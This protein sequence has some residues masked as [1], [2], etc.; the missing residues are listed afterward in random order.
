MPVELGATPST[1]TPLLR[2]AEES[3]RADAGQD[4]QVEDRTAG[5][6]Q[7][8]FGRWSMYNLGKKVGRLSIE[9]GKLL[10]Y[11]SF[12]LRTVLKNDLNFTWEP[13]KRAWTKPVE[14]F[15]LMTGA[16]TS[17]TQEI[18]RLLV[19]S[20][21]KK[22]KEQDQ[23]QVSERSEDT[24]GSSAGGSGREEVKV[25]EGEGKLHVYN[26]YQVKEEL[27]ALGFVFDSTRKSWCMQLFAALNVLD[28]ASSSQVDLEVIRRAASSSKLAPSG[29]LSVSSSRFTSAEFE[30]TQVKLS[31]GAVLTLATEL[32]E[33]SGD[34]TVAGGH[35]EMSTDGE[36]AASC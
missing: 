7:D 34:G 2:V 22:V 5:L 6:A 24:S 16:A 9:D 4:E 30:A 26:S 33:Q 3:Q 11:Q 32:Q 10:A 12:P 18:F 31:W 25:E 36:A 20:Y 29:S 28:V 17:D 21:N 13:E 27:K 1:S 19:Q 23:K 8:E 15:L 14:E 35:G